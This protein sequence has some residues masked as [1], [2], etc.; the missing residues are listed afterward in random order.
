[1][2]DPIRA[3]LGRVKELDEKATDGPWEAHVERYQGGE[4]DYYGA[5][6]PNVADKVTTEY[7]G[8]YPPF[9]EDADAELTAQYRTIAPQLA[10]ALEAV[11][12]VHYEEDGLNAHQVCAHRYCIDDAGDQCRWPCM[13]VRAI[14]E[15]LGVKDG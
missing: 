12:E 13:T 7:E 6:I 1:M 2:T 14:T 8:D 11:L 15:H 5:H 9:W 10:R 4:S 3:L